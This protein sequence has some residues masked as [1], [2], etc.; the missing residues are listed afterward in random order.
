MLEVLFEETHAR[1][2]GGGWIELEFAE[3][4]A[5]AGVC[6]SGGMGGWFG[7]CKAIDFSC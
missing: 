4:V 5:C 2:W 3:M 1:G 7:S 6:V